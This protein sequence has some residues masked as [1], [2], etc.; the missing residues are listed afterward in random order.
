FNAYDRALQQIG[1]KLDQMSQMAG[2]R[3]AKAMRSFIEQDDGIAETVI[4][5]DDEIDALDEEIEMESIDL[6]LL[7]QPVDADLRFLIAAMRISRELERISDYACDIAEAALTLK[8]KK[9]FFK[10]LVDLPEMARLVQEMMGKSLKAHLG[11][12]VA[13]AK[14]MDAADDEVDRIFLALLQEL[15]GWMKKG[16]EYVEQASI[17]LLVARYLERIGDHIVNISE[18]TIFIETGER[19]PFKTN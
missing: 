6:I 17:I 9:P 12:D 2:E 15:M 19:H 3:L 5:G 10:P 16:P 1:I 11:K 13:T 18:M 14:Q 7:Q 8:E 4:A